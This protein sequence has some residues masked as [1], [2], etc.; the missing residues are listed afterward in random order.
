M[1]SYLPESLFTIGLTIFI[2]LSCAQSG[3]DSKIA[4]T[5]EDEPSSDKIVLIFEK[6]KNEPGTLR[7]VYKLDPEKV[8][9]MKMM[10]AF[11]NNAIDFT[12]LNEFNDEENFLVNNFAKNDTFVIEAKKPKAFFVNAYPGHLTFRFKPGDTARFTYLPPRSFPAY[13]GFI[14]T[15]PHE[16]IYC[17]VNS[18]ET[19]KQEQSYMYLKRSLDGIH[20]FESNEKRFEIHTKVLDSLKADGSLNDEYYNFYRD[21]LRYEYLS[22]FQPTKE[23]FDK[24]FTP[25][26]LTKDEMVETQAYRM[27][28]KNYVGNTVMQGKNV[29]ISGGISVDFKRA[30]DSIETKF[31][32]RVRDYLLVS[33]VKG[34]KSIET[35][36]VYETYADR[37]T[38]HMSNDAFTNYF[39]T[40]YSPKPAP[41]S[42][43][44]VL[45]T[46]GNTRTIE[47]NDVLAKEKGKVIYV[48]LW[49]SWCI[50]CRASMPASEKLRRDFK[51][52]VSFV[53]L[54]IDQKYV[55][56]EIASRAEK[57]LDYNNTYLMTDPRGAALIKKINLE[58]IPRYLVYN[59]K[60]QLVNA[61]APGPQEIEA[62]R[63][64]NKLVAE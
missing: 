12:I 58:S 44:T 36:K 13:A 1:K 64:L 30:Y 7:G 8:R 11:R 28:L 60:G 32:G 48:D 20:F 22:R 19:T 46:I 16:V 57:L 40:N 59:K 37:L 62:R 24:Y 39:N 29:K 25:E 35:Q 14:Y 42:S 34:L 49:A 6:T 26:D 55:S 4:A 43:N 56:W 33:C 41:V 50:P 18:R 47:F 3:S 38:K 61:N 63:L 23:V 17:T 5:K 10:E 9:S 51:D 54:S 27:F 15:Y 2:F 21:N 45:T 31:D 52:K 53:Y